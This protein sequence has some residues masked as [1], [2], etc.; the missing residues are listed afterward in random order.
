[1]YVLRMSLSVLQIQR[2]KPSISD[3]KQQ[4]RFDPTISTSSYQ[5]DTSGRG[6]VLGEEEKRGHTPEGLHERL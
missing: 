4:K 1:V 5:V 6:T 3:H 2:P